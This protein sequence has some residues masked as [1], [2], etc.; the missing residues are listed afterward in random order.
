MTK[1]LGA[2]KFKEK[3]LSLLESVDSE[4]L[5][6]TKN[7]KP[8]AKL[9]AYTEDQASYIGKFKSLIKIHGNIHSTGVKW[10]AES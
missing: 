7:G 8:V 3:C 9:I 10:N 6:I 4:G 1:T 5:I 2:A